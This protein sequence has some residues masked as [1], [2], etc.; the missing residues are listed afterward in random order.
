[1]E[2]NV[3]RY[4]NQIPFGDADFKQVLQAGRIAARLAGKAGRFGRLEAG[5]LVGGNQLV[6]ELAQVAAQLGLEIRARNAAQVADNKLPLDEPVNCGVDK[7]VVADVIELRLQLLPVVGRHQRGLL[8]Q[9]AERLKDA[10][11]QFL[12]HVGVQQQTSSPAD[13]YI[14]Q[15]PASL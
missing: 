14:D 3:V 10:V 6:F 15:V 8:V 11:F 1:M 5:L 7:S 12:H 9:P 2:I 13:R 4:L